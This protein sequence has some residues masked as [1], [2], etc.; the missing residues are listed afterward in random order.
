LITADKKYH[1]ALR[2]QHQPATLN[3][4]DAAEFC[5]ASIA[6]RVRQSPTC[7]STAQLATRIDAITID[8]VTHLRRFRRLRFAGRFAGAVVAADE[9]FSEFSVLTAIPHDC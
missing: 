7:D 2:G 4:P 6:T 8:Q 5:R 1:S 3:Q 9:A